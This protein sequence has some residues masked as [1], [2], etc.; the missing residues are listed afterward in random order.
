MHHTSLLQ[1]LQPQ[2]LSFTA[3]AKPRFG[4]LLQAQFG[5]P[6]RAP[7]DKSHAG[8]EPFEAYSRGASVSPVVGQ[9]TFG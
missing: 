7:A 1:D 6:F 4:L 8:A 5:A 3:E 2:T 9:L